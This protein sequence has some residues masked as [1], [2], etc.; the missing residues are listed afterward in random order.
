MS[1]RHF[2]EYSADSSIT[3]IL[4]SDS[5]SEDECPMEE[6]RHETIHWGAD[7]RTHRGTTF[8]Q[9]LGSPTR[10]ATVRQHALDVLGPDLPPILEVPE[11]DEDDSHDSYMFDEGHPAAMAP[12]AACNSVSSFSDKY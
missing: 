7:G 11:P 8:S 12:R 1:K 4:Y 6:I 9:I 3:S 5:E 2:T 10:R